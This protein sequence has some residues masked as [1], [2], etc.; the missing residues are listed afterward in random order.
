MHLP[1]GAGILAYNAETMII[2]GKEVPMPRKAILATILILA[3]ACLA[4]QG[5]V[6]PAVAAS[7]R[8]AIAEERVRIAIANI[9]YPVTPG[10]I[11]QLSYNQSAG[12]VLT[13][14]LVVSGDYSVDLG[15]F[16][17]I[18]AAG[19]TFFE[20]K[21]RVESL[22]VE[23]YTRS[24][25]SLTL[26]STGAFHIA[27]R[28]EVLRGEYP[29]AWGLTRLSEVAEAARGPNAS[30]RIVEVTGRD[31]ETR[32][33]DLLRASRLGIAD[34]DPLVK[35]GETIAFRR[36]MR[37]V[38]L[39]GEVWQPGSYELAPEEGLRELID[40]FG[41]GLTDRAELSRVRIDHGSEGGTRSDY[42]AL[43]EAYAS[44][45]SL[46]YGDAVTVS[47]RDKHRPVVW[48]EGA[49]V[50][51]AA[52]EPG[53]AQEGARAEGGAVNREAAG[54]RISCPVTAGEMLSDALV[55]IRDSI[56][57]N[58]DLASAVLL[59]Q[60]RAAPIP[61]NLQALLSGAEQAS[62]LPLEA[63]DRVFIPLLISTVSVTGAVNNAGV[64]A[65]Q[66]GMLA[67]YY[68]GLAAGIDPS[69][70]DNGKYQV[71]DPRGKRRKAAD[72]IQP[73]DQVYVPSNSQE[74]RLMTR[75]PIWTG[76]TGTFIGVVSLVVAL[77]F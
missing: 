72:P 11:Y 63:N 73:G 15:F 23:S 12:V 76:I 32:R 5:A 56:A 31:G 3:S 77:F 57:P 45:L 58:A 65:Y 52:P 51:P 40:I 6:E 68:I 49:V 27:V 54:R 50:Q 30:V 2:V 43:P 14:E 61:V 7:D 25:P 29:T 37:L 44:S 67:W 16:G 60:G 18:D 17:K 48:F 59:R 10:D 22:V 62:D 8:A 70:N 38:T 9:E 64:Y 74:Y 55:S 19:L 33:Y 75:A 24:L 35:P 26:T 34:Q 36:V 46:Q 21:R 47:S 28:G 53:G 69:R 4:A 1:P 66:P 42:V 41:G 13:R 71:I 39:S 20:L